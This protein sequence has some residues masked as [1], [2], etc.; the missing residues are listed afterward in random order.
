VSTTLLC[1]LFLVGC[2]GDPERE[3]LFDH[4]HEAPEHWPRNLGDTTAK[5]RQRLERLDS[6]DSDAASELTDLVSWT[7]EVAADT[8]MSEQQWTPIW[9]ASEK[10]RQGLEKNN[11][12]WD[13][14]S[15]QQV[16]R[17]CV[18]ID[19]A[20]SQLPDEERL[21]VRHQSHRH[22]HDGHDHDGHD[23]DGHDHDGHDHDDHDHDEPGNSRADS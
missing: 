19:A 9:E 12:T 23:H 14:E 17:L 15:R 18:L 22:H 4:S 1:S 7:P 3:T 6:N 21:A 13:S 10:L 11:E 20:W 5:I 8:S 2:S 16:L